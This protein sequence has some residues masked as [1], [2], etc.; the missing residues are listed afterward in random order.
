MR[1]YLRDGICD[2][3]AVFI[4][5]IIHRGGVL[6]EFVRPADADDRCVAICFSLNSSKTRLP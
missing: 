2:S 5:E 1:F 3:Q 6:D 4:A